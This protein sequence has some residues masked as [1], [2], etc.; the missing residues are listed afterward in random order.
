MSPAA[1]RDDE[2][3]SRGNGLLDH[4]AD[5]AGPATSSRTAAM[6]SV[7]TI[8]WMPRE[9]ATRLQRARGPPLS[10]RNAD[11]AFPRPGGNSLIERGGRDGHSARLATAARRIGHGGMGDIYLAT[12]TLL[13]RAVA[14]KLLAERYAADQSIRG[15]FTR[16][17]L[18]AA[19]SPATQYGD[20]LRRRRAQRSPVHRHGVPEGGSLEDSIRKEGAQ[21]PG[22]VLGGWSRRRVRSTRRT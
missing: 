7:R 3:G 17:A 4:R 8:D 18:A 15:R 21:P 16:E 22:R 12:D 9:D 11:A 20:D 1:T 10:L 14:M 19:G 13:G 5:A 6:R 2:G